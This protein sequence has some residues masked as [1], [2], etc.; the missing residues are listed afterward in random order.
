MLRLVKRGLR[1]SRVLYLLRYSSPL[2]TYM[3]Q[4]W[5][6]LCKDCKESLSTHELGAGLKY[7]EQ[8]WSGAMY[9]AIMML[10]TDKTSLGHGGG[11]FCLKDAHPEYRKLIEPV[12]GRWFGK[13]VEF[14]GDYTETPEFKDYS[15][16]YTNIT[17]EVAT[18]VY[19]IVAADMFGSEIADI[20]EARKSFLQFLTKEV[21]EYKTWEN[22]ASVRAV[23]AALQRI[24]GQKY[25]E[26]TGDPSSSKKRKGDPSPPSNKRKA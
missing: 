14:V 15:E 23:F 8:W 6:W 2:R 7:L 9:T 21:S 10:N 25:K 11:D 3:G 5:E 4:Y 24:S 17:T 19:A 22:E 20:S 12:I 16:S 13:R 18:A 1:S 26:C